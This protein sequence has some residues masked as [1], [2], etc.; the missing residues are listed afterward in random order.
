MAE[1]KTEN[2]REALTGWPMIIFYLAMLVFAIHSCTRMVAAGDTWVAMACGRHFLAHGVDTVEPFSANS[3]KPGPT[4]A[5]LSKYPEWLRGTVKRWHPTGWV[6]QNWLTHVMFYWLTNKS[7]FAD[8][9]EFK[10]ESLTYWKLTICIL[11]VI[12]VYYMGRVLGV[13]PA[14]SAIF[15]CFAVF[16]GRSFIDIRPQ[17]FTNLLVSIFV[18]ILILTTYRNILYIWLIVPLGVFWCN[19]HGGY[20]Y[21]FIMLV[22][23]VACNFVGCVSRKWFISIGFRGIR[24]TILAGLT[25]FVAVIVFNPFHL[26]NLTHTFVVSVSK[27][28]ELW[29]TVNEWHPAFEWSNPVGTGVPFAVMF[30]ILLLLIPIWL[31]ALAM[32]PYRSAKWEKLQLGSEHGEYQWPGIDLA[33]ITIAVLTVYMAIRSR[34]FIPIA[35]NVACPVMAMFFDQSVRMISARWNFNRQRRLIVSPMP[36]RLQMVFTFIAAAAVI[37]F[38]TWWGLKIKRIYFDPWPTDR[39]FTSIFMRLTA[40]YAK[41]FYAGQFI[42]ENK[43]KGKMFNYWT[44]GGFIAW[45]QDPDPNTGKTPLQLFMDG[46]A[47]AAYK[48]DDY[49]LWAGIMGG[50]PIMRK[51]A[52]VGRSPTASEIDQIGRWI[53]EQF[54]KRGV[55][56][57]LMPA[58]QFDSTFMMSLE[59]Q[60]NWR[61]V[62][63]SDKQKMLVNIDTPQGIDLLNGLF[64][65]ET[66]YPDDAHK[67]LALAYN[68]LRSTDEKL[69][70]QGVSFAAKSLELDPSQTA[71]I[72]ILSAVQRRPGLAGFVDR[73]LNDYLQ[74][75]EDNKDYYR[76]KDGYARRLL[77]AILAAD[78][79]SKTS[80]DPQVVQVNTERVKDYKA[81][82]DIIFKNT[83][84]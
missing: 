3:H 73:I 62:F 51:I 7:P 10:F 24:H 58:N 25:A 21:I 70:V 6:N 45:A 60:T 71:M 26:T 32:T 23:F 78:W 48:A 55:W 36:F 54:R 41:P 67:F 34:R 30:G 64:S 9:K 43:L 33:L 47:Q 77:P 66:K 16:T 75:F 2:R 8:A 28:A 15:A 12:C 18:L 27:H 52:I 72:E 46:R 50:G 59:R 1:L 44:E 40:S 49:R 19:I 74:N 35:A 56:V 83:Q 29:R 68:M 20:I 57:V 22:P 79:L 76:R 84:W 39:K 38:G 17:I 4:A 31:V 42:R 53:D 14:L 11:T 65:D 80:K 13:N 81:E 63:V 82:K 5:E 69:V 61:V 37:F